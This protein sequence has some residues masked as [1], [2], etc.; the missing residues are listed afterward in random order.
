MSDDRGAPIP[1]HLQ[2]IVYGIAFFAGSQFLMISVIMPL[3][4]LELGAS[5]FFI[6][7]IVS[8]RQVL[9]ITLSI[10][11]GTLLD[12]FGPR[13]VIMCLGFAGAGLTLLFPLLPYLWATV[14]LQMAT[15][16][17]EVTCW[18]GAQAL[19]GG[20]LKGRPDYAG[21]MTAAS[22]IG[23]FCGPIL[24]GLVWETF[25]AL[26]A[27]AFVAT[28]VAC[29]A[30]VAW[31]LPKVTD[32]SVPLPVE[33]ESRSVLPSLTDYATTFRLLLLPAVA[34]VI[35]TTFMR[36]AGSGIQSSF[37]VIWIKEIGFSAS[38]IG[39]LIG[40]SNAVAAFAALATGPLA[41]RIAA[42]WLLIAVT[43]LSVVAIAITPMLGSLL[44]LSVAIGLR[45]VGQGLNLPLMLSIASRAVGPH[46]QGRVAALRLSFNKFGG[47]I[48]PFVM[49]AIA[50]VA[51][52]EWSFY[53]V[54]I[55]GVVALVF[56]GL[57]VALSPRLKAEQSHIRS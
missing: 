14:M 16:F 7:L 17:A 53:I 18:I 4:A 33:T 34:L 49:G 32:E 37:Y 24:V 25:G 50:E 31:C 38:T 45:G 21:R 30:I 41:R 56:L 29:F 5:P 6:G 12:R 8:S 23:G 36:Q 26:V 15:G 27:F 51:G 1:F 40:V 57:W 43:I 52:L 9:V 54:G 44:A 47:A 55:T 48:V 13:R 3:W 22:R 19:T 11:G 20:L 10:H 35:A 28:W 42:D 46:L 39:F 2:G